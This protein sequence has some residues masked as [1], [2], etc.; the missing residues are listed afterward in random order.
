MPSLK[1]INIIVIV[2]VIL[3]IAITNTF[4]FSDKKKILIKDEKKSKLNCHKC[5]V[6]FDVKEGIPILIPK[7][8]E[9]L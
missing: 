6:N 8:M 2:I 4:T 1:K 5:I 7:N 9:P 3:S